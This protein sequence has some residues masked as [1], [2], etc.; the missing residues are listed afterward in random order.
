M[1]I[2]EIWGLLRFV[3]QV[4]PH[5]AVKQ[6]PGTRF[7]HFWFAKTTGTMNTNHRNGRMVGTEMILPWL[8]TRLG[9]ISSIWNGNRKLLYLR[10]FWK[11]DKTLGNLVARTVVFES[12]TLKRGPEGRQLTTFECNRSKIPRMCCF[13]TVIC[14]KLLY[15]NNVFWEFY[16][17]YTQMWWVVGLLGHVWVLQTQKLLF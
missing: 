7:C 9:R 12:T 11:L 4:A 13:H 14:S 10:L 1:E 2:F 16:F 17:C 15:E 6:V 8:T 3:W 5:F